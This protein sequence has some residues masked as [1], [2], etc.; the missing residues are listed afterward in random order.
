MAGDK[1]LLAKVRLRLKTPTSPLHVALISL[2]SRLR[3]EGNSNN[4]SRQL[5][6]CALMGFL[7]FKRNAELNFEG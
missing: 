4:L 3:F 7:V 1:P 6:L 2:V 5:N